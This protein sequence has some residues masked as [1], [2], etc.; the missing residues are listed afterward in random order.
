MGFTLFRRGE[1]VPCRQSRRPCASWPKRGSPGPPGRR[2]ITGGPAKVREG[3]EALA[4][5]YGAEEVMIVTITHEHA[6]RRRS[7]ELIAE[8]FGLGERYIGSNPQIPWRG[9]APKEPSMKKKSLKLNLTRETLQ[10]LEP[11]KD[12]L[13]GV[14]GGI[15]NTCGCTKGS[16]LC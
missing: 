3:I 12:P 7:Y 11:G 16:C 1:L 10:A 5:E 15:T 4:R 9:R 14:V 13:E 6:T 2:S 8:A